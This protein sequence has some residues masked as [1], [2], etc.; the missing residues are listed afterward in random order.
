MEE[1]QTADELAGLEVEDHESLV[2]FL[3]VT[4]RS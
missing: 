4:R 2:D 3:A 1:K